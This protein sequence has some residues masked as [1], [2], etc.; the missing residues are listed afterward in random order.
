[1]SAT[2]SENPSHEYVYVHYKI[3]SYRRETTLQDTLVLAKSGRL[4]LEYNI[5]FG[6]YRSRWSGHSIRSLL[7]CVLQSLQIRTRQ[8]RQRMLGVSVLLRRYS[9]SFSAF[10]TTPSPKSDLSCLLP[11]IISS[12]VSLGRG[13]G[14][15][16]S[17]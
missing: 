15:R 6:N 11:M 14:D 4:E 3:L 9:R 2:R 5:F 8:L 16:P 1:M 7:Y 10:T 12:V 13:A 17:P